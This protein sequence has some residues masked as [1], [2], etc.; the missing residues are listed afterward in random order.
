MLQLGAQIFNLLWATVNGWYGRAKKYLPDGVGSM[1]MLAENLT[2]AAATTT[3]LYT[4]TGTN[5]W[6]WGFN[7]SASAGTGAGQQRY[8]RLNWNPTVGAKENIFT[9][10][11]NE[12]DNDNH[13]EMFSRP[14]QFS[15]AGVLEVESSFAAVSGS[16]VVYGED[17]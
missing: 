4:K 15:E 2:I 14:M 11:I 5:L 7:L 10:W 16:C 8:L 6:L 13:V 17:I 9:I 1:R 3:T 12:G